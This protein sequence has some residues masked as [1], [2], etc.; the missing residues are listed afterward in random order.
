MKVQPPETQTPRQSQGYGIASC[1]LFAIILLVWLASSTVFEPAFV[2]VSPTTERWLLVVLLVLPAIIGAALGAIGLR[3]AREKK[4][5]SWIGM[6]LNGVF[7]LFFAA[8]LAFA[9]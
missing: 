4:L 2:G 3:Q 6:L 9:G 8:I 5:W 7:A 1:I